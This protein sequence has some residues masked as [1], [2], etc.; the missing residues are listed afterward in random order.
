[1]DT[2]LSFRLKRN[3]IRSSMKEEI[4]RAIAYAAGTRIN[5]SAGSSI[6]RHERG[7]HSHM[8]PTYDYD[9]GAHVSRTGGGLYHYGTSSHVSFSATGRNFSGYDYESG[10]HY[11]GRVSGSSVQLYDYGEGRYFSYSV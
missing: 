11:T 2:I 9:A 8:T 5:A 6:Y 10:H 3:R 1:V 4:R 7:R